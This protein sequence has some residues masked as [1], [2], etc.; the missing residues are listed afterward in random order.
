VSD[1]EWNLVAA[2]PSRKHLRSW[3][4]ID[5]APVVSVNMAIDVIDQGIDLFAAA[6]AD[7]PGAIWIPQNL[8]RYIYQ[9]PKLQLWISFRPVT[10]KKRVRELPGILK[11]GMTKKQLDNEITL[12]GVPLALIW[13]KCLP[14][15]TGTRSL[16]WGEVEDVNKK[17][18]MRSAFTTVCALERIF[19]YRPKKVRILCADMMGPWIEGKTEKE[20]VAAERAKAKKNKGTFLDRWKHE[21]AA[22][23]MTIKKGK[24]AFGVEVEYVTPEAG[25][26]DT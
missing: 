5:G 20:C 4:L 6:F 26:E 25:D 9:H 23:R 16:P 24:E 1:S 13:D 8:E 18:S 22:M 10:E 15:L 3:H 14:A 2:G 11:K 7:G 17:G 12:P 19:Y 21:K